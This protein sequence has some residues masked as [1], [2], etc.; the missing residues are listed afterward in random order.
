[1]SAA[2]SKQVDAGRKSLYFCWKAVLWG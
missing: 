1:M 2:Y